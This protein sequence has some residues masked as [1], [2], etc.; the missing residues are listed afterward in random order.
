MIL[1]EYDEI[2]AREY[3]KKES[4]EAGREEG[5]EIGREEGREEGQ[6]ATFVRNLKNM[7]KNLGITA[8]EAMKILEVPKEQREKYL[9]ILEEQE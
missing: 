5:R 4:M 8:E 9:H 6:D 2:A 1:T 3:L 7:M